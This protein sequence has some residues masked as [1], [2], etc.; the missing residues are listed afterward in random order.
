M[1]GFVSPKT[2]WVVFTASEVTTLWRSRN[3]YIIIIIIII[4]DDTDAGCLRDGGLVG[5]TWRT[6]SCCLYL[7][8]GDLLPVRMQLL[9]LLLRRPTGSSTA[10]RRTYQLH[11]PSLSVCLSVCLSTPACNWTES[12]ALFILLDIL[13]DKP[14]NRCRILRSSRGSY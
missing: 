4:V 1:V 10:L 11:Y 5:G 14:C 2:T 8:S 13:I 3:V 9:M 6:C 12:R 7:R